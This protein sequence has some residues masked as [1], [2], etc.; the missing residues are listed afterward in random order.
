MR[1]ICDIEITETLCVYLNIEHPTGISSKIKGVI[2][3]RKC[4]TF[5]DYF[6][7]NC[8]LIMVQPMLV[9]YSV[10]PLANTKFNM[11][12]RTNSEVRTSQ[13]YQ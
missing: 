6:K 3:F 8:I 7:K 2:F 11:I 13:N 5:L 10:Q 4:S 1:A 9:V 12:E